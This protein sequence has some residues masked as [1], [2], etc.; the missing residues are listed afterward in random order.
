MPT[1]WRNSDESPEY[2][3]LK[4]GDIYQREI[5]KLDFN[6]SGKV[7]TDLL[8]GSS[9]GAKS[10]PKFQNNIPKITE[11]EES[12]ITQ[13]LET[14]NIIIVSGPRNNKDLDSTET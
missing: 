10:M 11:T 13:A 2:S 14:K 1:R 5:K 3:Y 8:S 4:P 9:L 12:K 6:N 7:L